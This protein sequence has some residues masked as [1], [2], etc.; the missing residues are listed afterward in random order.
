MKYTLIIATLLCLASCTNQKSPYFRYTVE[1]HFT[2][3]EIDTLVL[4][5]AKTQNVI[6]NNGCIEIEKFKNASLAC[7]VKYFK[8]IKREVNYY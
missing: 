5:D 4:P 6:I 3:G 2:D 8:V 1:V 7:Q